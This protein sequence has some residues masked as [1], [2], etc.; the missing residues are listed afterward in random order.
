MPAGPPLPQTPLAD[1]RLDDAPRNR[2]LTRL[3]SPTRRQAVSARLWRELL[4]P[5]AVCLHRRTAR[6]D[7]DRPAA[8]DTVPPGASDTLP[9]GPTTAP[10]PRIRSAP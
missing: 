4:D 7:W 3:C 1:V 5:A 9:P 6:P 8:E 2:W 10:H